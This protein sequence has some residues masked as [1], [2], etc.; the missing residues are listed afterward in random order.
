MKDSEW[1]AFVK[2]YEWSNFGHTDYYKV[3]TF[4]K[5]PKVEMILV[6]NGHKLTVNEKLRAPET[7][8]Y[9]TRINPDGTK[10]FIDGKTINT[11]K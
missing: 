5:K 2:D 11:L 3:I 4:N 7:H 6:S 8:R 10:V 1:E 9:P